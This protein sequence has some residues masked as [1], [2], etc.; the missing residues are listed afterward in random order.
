M[1]AAETLYG[2]TDGEA[3]RV[4]GGVGPV[5]AKPPASAAAMELTLEVGGAIA[6]R[7]S[8]RSAPACWWRVVGDRPRRPRSSRR[9]ETSP[10]RRPRVRAL[11]RALAARREAFASGSTARSARRRARGHAGRARR[12]VSIAADV[13]A[14]TSAEL[15]ERIR[16]RGV[17]VEPSAL[18]ARCAASCSTLLPGRARCRSPSRRP[19]V[20]LVT[21]VNGVGRDDDD[22]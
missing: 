9:R 12:G 14:R 13:G 15:R 10:G 5:A 6:A 2:I 4:E 7:R 8:A 11:A 17:P 1:E 19:W 20:V 21:G 3:G 18:R 16:G 22:R